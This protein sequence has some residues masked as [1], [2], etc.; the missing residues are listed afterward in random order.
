MLN[1]FNELPFKNAVII[2][3]ASFVGFI[4]ILFCV[5]TSFLRRT[6]DAADENS[7]IKF[8]YCGETPQ[9]LC[10]L[11]FG[12]DGSGDTIINFFVPDKKFQDFYLIVKKAGQ[13]S[14]Y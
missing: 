5:L 13:E 8:E 3:T 6:N 1:R 10:V 4:F 2:V 7:I 14:R 12:H 9:E 11:S